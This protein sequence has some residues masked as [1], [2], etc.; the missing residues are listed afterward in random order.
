MGP[1]P[2][3]CGRR[4]TWAAAMRATARFNG[5]A[6]FRLRKVNESHMG[7]SM[8]DA[9]MGP[10]PFGCGRLWLRD[11]T[12]RAPPLQ[13]GRNLS[14][15]EGRRKRQLVQ[16]ELDASMGPQP[17]GCGRDNKTTSGPSQLVGFNGAATFRLRKG[18]VTT[19]PRGPL[20]R[21]NG[22]A[23]FRLR[24]VALPSPYRPDVDSLQWGRNLSVAEGAGRPSAAP[25]GRASM[26]P[27]PFGCGRDRMEATIDPQAWLQWG[28]N[29]SVAEGW[30]CG[31]DRA[32][33]CVRFNGA[34][35]FRLRK[36]ITMR[37][38]PPT[39]RASMGPQPFGCGRGSEDVLFFDA[40][41]LQWG[42]NLSVA[43]GPSP[44][45]LPHDP[46]TLQWGRNLSVAEGATP[47]ASLPRGATASMGPQP[48]GCGRYRHASY[49]VD[50]TDASMGPQP[51]GCGRVGGHKERRHVGLLQWG[52]NLSVAE[53]LTRGATRP[54]PC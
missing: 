11:V 18:G 39:W 49:Y 50:W 48:F 44:D 37:G 26:G 41:M 8:F 51:F 31:Q 7:R 5:A 38:A 28:R 10:Q 22:A 3:G 30:P 17:F 16:Q 40:P 54:A 25:A 53:G 12:D 4:K 1:Q 36:D 9:S 52:R 33:D 45:A 21:F 29:L 2:F 46:A 20:S 14:V 13:W 23:T 47:S 43:E 24:K 34:A 35:T 6:T 15:A 32:R 19:R 42:R 27:Q